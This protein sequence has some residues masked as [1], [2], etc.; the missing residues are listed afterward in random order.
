MVSNLYD[1]LGIRYCFGSE[2]Y[3]ENILHLSVL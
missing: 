2:F 1:S 3:D